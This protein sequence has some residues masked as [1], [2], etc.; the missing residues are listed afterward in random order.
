MAER[1]RGEQHR[2]RLLADVAVAN[3]RVATFDASLRKDRLELD[4]RFQL[5]VLAVDFFERQALRTW[6]VPRHVMFHRATLLDAVVIRA[7]AGVDDDEARRAGLG[8]PQS[9]IRQPSL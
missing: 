5:Q 8:L 9:P 4:G 3:H 7:V 6:N 2:S 1:S